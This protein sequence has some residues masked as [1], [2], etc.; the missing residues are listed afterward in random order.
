M[1]GRSH[2]HCAIRQFVSIFESSK[3]M[4][5]L[6]KARE[7]IRRCDDDIRKA[8]LKRMEAVSKVADYKQRHDRPVYVK[9]QEKAVL[10][11]C[12]GKGQDP[13]LRKYYLDLVQFCI[14]LSKQYQEELT[15]K[16]GQIEKKGKQDE[17]DPDTEGEHI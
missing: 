3:T 1:A 10:E 17:S 12:A 6:E 15:G 4:N 8:F 13:V 5:E 11:R 2:E 14:D 9:E 16:S 7:E